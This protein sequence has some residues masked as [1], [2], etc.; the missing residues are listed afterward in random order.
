MSY[1]F[2]GCEPSN[3]SSSCQFIYSFDT[4]LS[5]FNWWANVQQIQK[6]TEFSR[7]SLKSQARVHIPELTRVEDGEW[8]N[9]EII[10]TKHTPF[11]YSPGIWCPA[12][13]NFTNWEE[14]YTEVVETAP[15][16][17]K[18]SN[19]ILFFYLLQ[20]EPAR[21][22]LSLL[23]VWKGVT[24]SVCHLLRWSLR[25][26]PYCLWKESFLFSL[27]YFVM[28]RGRLFFASLDMNNCPAR[29]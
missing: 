14:L 28:E 16:E 1:S 8:W 15:K 25:Q 27:F 4:V 23:I 13:L 29:A 10:L 17:E 21:N 22:S 12:L 19:N 6:H 9:S 24:F 3:H 2:P 26:Q 7:V 5:L 20:A 11:Y 18:K